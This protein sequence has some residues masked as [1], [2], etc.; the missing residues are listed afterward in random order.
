MQSEFPTIKPF[1]NGITKLRV[2]VVLAT[3]KSTSVRVKDKLGNSVVVFAEIL[4]L[5]PHCNLCEEFG[6]LPLRCPFPRAHSKAPA[7]LASSS[8]SPKQAPSSKTVAEDY[9]P[10]VIGCALTPVLALAE[11]IPNSPANVSLDVPSQIIGPTFQPSQDQDHVPSAEATSSEGNPSEDP[12]SISPSLP[13]DPSPSEHQVALAE[14]VSACAN[15]DVTL[16]SSDH[17]RNSLNHDLPPDDLKGWDTVNRRSRLP[18]PKAGPPTSAVS[19]TSSQVAADEEVIKAAQEVLRRKLAE[20]ELVIPPDASTSA[21]KKARRDH[22]QKML[23]LSSSD[24]ALDA[25]DSLISTN[26]SAAGADSVS[27]RTRSRS[28]PPTNN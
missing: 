3:A 16:P 17:N 4:K 6:H 20:A 8:N 2:E 14:K 26:A 21:R 15:A 7:D 12:A 19:A 27:G 24:A 28:V 10:P 5:P 13:K 9:P 22:R 1:T 18:S 25:V 11:D 23:W